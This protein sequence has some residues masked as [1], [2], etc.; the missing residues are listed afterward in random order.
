MLLM[1]SCLL[2]HSSKDSWS[3]SAKKIF[4]YSL[5]FSQQNSRY[6]KV[7]WNPVVTGGQFLSDALC[8]S[9]SIWNCITSFPTS[10]SGKEVVIC[11]SHKLLLQHS[12]TESLSDCLCSSQIIL[13]FNNPADT[14]WKKTLTSCLGS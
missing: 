6:M 10:A 13:L 9:T 8:T 2:H 12:H 5:L 11:S 3:L 4:I 14:L 1:F 7:H